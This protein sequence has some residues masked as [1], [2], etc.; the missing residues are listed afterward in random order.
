MLGPACNLFLREIDFKIG[1]SLVVNK[2][3]APGFFLFILYIILEILVPL[4]YYNLTDAYKK[5]QEHLRNDSN[6]PNDD[7][8]QPNYSVTS[9]DETSNEGIAVNMLS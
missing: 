9:P 8:T 2:L 4:C 7:S 1:S 5:E 6:E 3:N